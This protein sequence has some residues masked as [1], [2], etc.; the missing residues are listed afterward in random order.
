MNH[1]DFPLLNMEQLRHF[2]KYLMCYT[3]ERV[4]YPFCMCKFRVTDFL[5]TFYIK[6]SEKRSSTD[7][8]SLANTL[9]PLECIILF[10]SWLMRI[11]TFSV[12]ETFYKS[13]TMDFAVNS[14]HS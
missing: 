6:L 13:M 3:D 14:T 2:S 10:Q 7:S 11:F 8:S 5:D 9:D 4:I 12:N 1:I